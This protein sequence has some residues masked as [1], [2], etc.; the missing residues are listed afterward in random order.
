[1]EDFLVGVLIFLA[2]GLAFCFWLWTMFAGKCVQQVDTATTRATWL[3]LG[4]FA[5]ALALPAAGF[6]AQVDVG[7][8]IAVLSA[9]FIWLLPVSLPSFANYV[10]L[11]LAV[12]LLCGR[13]APLGWAVLALVLMLSSLVFDMKFGW[14][15]LA[16]LVSACYLIAAC[17]LAEQRSQRWLVYM[18]IL[19]VGL[20][21]LFIAWGWVSGQL[22]SEPWLVL[23]GIELINM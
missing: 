3:A 13:R 20:C 12:R 19:A 21:A 22:M 15:F 2:Y 4:F 16:W 7:A 23:I 9:A 18:T 17:A 1:M 14:G 6:D 5:A 8:V 10:V 11:A